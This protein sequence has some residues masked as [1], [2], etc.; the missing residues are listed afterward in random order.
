MSEKIRLRIA[1][2][3]SGRLHKESL[4]ILFRCGLRIKSSKNE[5]FCQGENLDI[6]LLLVRDDDIPVLVSDDVCDVGIVG[7]NVLFERALELEF[8]AHQEFQVIKKLG[9]GACRLS[10]AMPKQR[11]YQDSSSIQG[12]RIATTYP[13]L[14]KRYLNENNIDAEIIHLAGSVEIAPRLNIAELICDLV[15]TGETLDANNLY[16]ACIILSS[17][18]VLFKTKKLPEI[19]QKIL[20]ML[21]LR[22]NAVL[23]VQE[24]KYIMF[25]LPKNKLD[26]IKKLLPG[27]ETPSILP[28]NNDAKKVA[29]HLVSQENVFWE[30]LEYLK[31]AGA[32]S[33]LVLPIE[34]M[35]L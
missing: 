8:Q 5:L 7:E 3:K 4:D 35:L 34:K 31:N 9:F 33:I 21:L 26:C 15:A 19:K 12:L 10:L 17:E 23:Q 24:S 29:I 2:Q 14:L 1:V 27:V 13:Y 16:E 6:D 28:L 20:D 22:L 25:H 30:T 32:S 11:N 18:A